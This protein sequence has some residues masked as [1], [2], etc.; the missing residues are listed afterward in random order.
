M[1][2]KLIIRAIVRYQS[3]VKVISV[4]Q[5]MESIKM[6]AGGGLREI[7][8]GHTALPFDRREV[9]NERRGMFKASLMIAHMY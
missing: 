5:N 7:A 9:F 3:G 8:G 4:D 1:G 2:G 6:I